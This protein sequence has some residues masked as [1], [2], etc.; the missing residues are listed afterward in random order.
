MGAILPFVARDA[1]RK[2]TKSPAGGEGAIIIFPGV[3]YERP[4][5]ADDAA[6][7][8]KAT[9]VRDMGPSKR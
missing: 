1:S 9:A 4:W 6:S 2:S 3:R 5:K 8:A 7:P